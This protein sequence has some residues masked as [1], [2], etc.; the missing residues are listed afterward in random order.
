MAINGKCVLC[1]DNDQTEPYWDTELG[2][3]QSCAEAFP[4]TNKIWDPNTRKC[5]SKCQEGFTKAGDDS[6]CLSCYDVNDH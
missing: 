6:K 3:C 5:V 2:V 1:A 4:D